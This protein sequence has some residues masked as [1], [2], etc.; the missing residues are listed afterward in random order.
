[1]HDLCA[2][3]LDGRDI[4]RSPGVAESN[5]SPPP[6]TQIYEFNTLD[7][8]VVADPVISSLQCEN[9]G[10]TYATAMVVIADAGTGM[11]EVFLK[12]SIQTAKMNGP[13]L[14]FPTITYDDEHV[15]ST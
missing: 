13:M 10:Q 2:D 5:D 12:H 9:I 6:G 7:E 14:P 4:L 1:M 15:H 11:K 8:V 3:E